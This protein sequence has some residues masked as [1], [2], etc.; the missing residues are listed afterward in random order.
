MTI[1]HVATLWS[2]T[3]GLSYRALFVVFYH[4]LELYSAVLSLPHPRNKTCMKKT[5]KKK[6]PDS[7]YLCSSATNYGFARHGDVEMSHH[8]H[9]SVLKTQT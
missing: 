2:R 7:S 8:R 3:G 6:H 5:E 1:K 4:R 9:Q